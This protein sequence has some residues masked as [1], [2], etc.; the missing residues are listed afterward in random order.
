MGI[1]EAVA[2]PGQH[3]DGGAAGLLYGGCALYLAGGFVAG[4][5]AVGRR[6]GLAAPAGQPVRRQ[7]RKSCTSMYASRLLGR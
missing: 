4:A 3:L 6:C 7:C 5:A 1:A 2:H